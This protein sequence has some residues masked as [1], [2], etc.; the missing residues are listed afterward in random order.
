MMS[1]YFV[2]IACLYYNV[3]IPSIY[4]VVFTLDYYRKLVIY[5][6]IIN[7]CQQHNSSYVQNIITKNCKLLY[8][9]KFGTVNTNRIQENNFTQQ[10]VIR[11]DKLEKTV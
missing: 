2:T 5:I 6:C 7:S 1:K 3:K 11:V 4:R 8:L 10:C 9:S